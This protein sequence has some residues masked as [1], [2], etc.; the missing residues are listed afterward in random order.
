M[1]RDAARSCSTGTMYTRHSNSPGCEAV[2]FATAWVQIAT[3]QEQRVGVTRGCIP[4]WL[5]DNGG[6]STLLPMSQ[7]RWPGFISVEVHA[8]GRNRFEPWPAC[9]RC[10]GSHPRSGGIARRPMRMS[11][12]LSS[13]A[14]ARYGRRNCKHFASHVRTGLEQLRRAGTTSPRGQPLCSLYLD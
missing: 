2:T 4:D 1:G 9:S 14:D 11:I 10:T 6:H 13:G 8:T 5:L 3:E 7:V 12:Q